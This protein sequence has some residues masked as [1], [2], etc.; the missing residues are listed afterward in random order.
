MI[1]RYLLLGMFAGLLAGLLAFGVGRVWGEPPVE[2]AIAIEEAGSAEAQPHS[3]ATTT[4][5][6]A[7]PEAHS[8]SHSHG[9]DAGGITRATQ[10]GIGLLTGMVVFGA[11]LGGLFALAFAFVEGRF[12]DLPA[13]GTAAVMAGLG[14][15][16]VVLVPFMKYPANPPAVGSG[17]T[18]GLRTQMFFIMLVLSLIAMI[19][20][21]VIARSG[22]DRWVSGVLG[23]LAY[24]ALVMVA[25]YVL[26]SIN[27]VP[28]GFPGDLLWQFRTVALAVQAVLWVS[29]GL[30]FGALVQRLRLK[31]PQLRHGII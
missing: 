17:E 24:A 6:T 26:P 3:H 31:Q 29:I 27:E 28:A 18:I 23:G 1:G 11:G 20:A 19:V 2:A 21:V 4:D 30:I 7:T 25:G 14:Y 12:S 16:S 9:D 13:R 10:A 22:R 8:H 15:I 5:A